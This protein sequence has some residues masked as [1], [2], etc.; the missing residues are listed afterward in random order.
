MYYLD[1]LRYTAWVLIDL[2]RPREKIPAPF[3]TQMGPKVEHIAKVAHNILNIALW[4]SNMGSLKKNLKSCFEVI[5]WTWQSRK[6]WLRY[7]PFSAISRVN[8]KRDPTFRH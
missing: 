8:F 3:L 2:M 6:Y 4:Q 5:Q 7:L 1:F